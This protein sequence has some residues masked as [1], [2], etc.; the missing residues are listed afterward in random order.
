MPKRRSHP[1][2]VKVPITYFAKR[3][4]PKKTQ[5]P[6]RR[7][8]PTLDPITETSPSPAP[9][10]TASPPRAGTPPFPFRMTSDPPGKTPETAF[11]V[12]PILTA[13]QAADAVDPSRDVPEVD[14]MYGPFSISDTTWFA[15]SELAGE[16]AKREEDARK[17][18]KYE[19]GKCNPPPSG[20]VDGAFYLMAHLGL[21]AEGIDSDSEESKE[22][23]EPEGKGKGVRRSKRI[24]MR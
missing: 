15:S 22:E 12:P 7:A 18:K 20:P 6:A 24:R 2:A 3:P 14:W 9:A 21:G 4:A 8:Q 5:E 17:A 23:E 11:V 1:R 13:E 16:R 10:T 19:A